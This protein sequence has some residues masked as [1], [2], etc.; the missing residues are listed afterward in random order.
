MPVR[1]NLNLTNLLIVIL[2]FLS[3]QT[4]LRVDTTLDKL[5][6]KSSDHEKRISV[7]EDR[8]KRKTAY[9]FSEKLCFLLPESIKVKE[10]K[11]E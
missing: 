11:Q 8:G 6:E 1:S 4:Y 7:L 2:G 3:V 9:N 10:E 5:V